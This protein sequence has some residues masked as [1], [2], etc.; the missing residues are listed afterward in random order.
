MCVGYAKKSGDVGG[1]I[2]S[3]KLAITDSKMCFKAWDN[4]CCIRVL[5]HC[6][7]LL[8]SFDHTHVSWWL[9]QQWVSC[10]A[11]TWDQ[12]GQ[13]CAMRHCCGLLYS[14]PSATSAIGGSEMLRKALKLER[15]SCDGCSWPWRFRKQFYSNG[16]YFSRGWCKG[17]RPTLCVLVG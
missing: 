4:G 17:N 8:T 5:D 1:S 3:V 6:T 10:Q 13:S 16:I 11:S 15:E 12:V 2:I 7:I 9:F 14:A